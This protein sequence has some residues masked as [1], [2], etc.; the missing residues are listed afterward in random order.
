[1]IQNKKA[2]S[3][4]GLREATSEN[5]DRYQNETT[6]QTKQ[7][8]KVHQFETVIAS[9]QETEA[10][11]L[12]NREYL[13][14]IDFV[15]QEFDLLLRSAPELPKRVDDT[16]NTRMSTD[17]VAAGKT[18]AEDFRS[19]RNQCKVHQPI[20]GHKLESDRSHR[21]NPTS[22]LAPKNEHNLVEVSKE[23]TSPIVTS[24]SQNKV[25]QAHPTQKQTTRP[26]CV[27]KGYKQAPP[28]TNKQT[29]VKTLTTKYQTPQTLRMKTKQAG[30]GFKYSNS[31]TQEQQ[32]VQPLTADSLVPATSYPSW[33]AS[34]TY[35]NVAEDIPHDTVCYQNVTSDVNMQLKDEASYENSRSMP[36]LLQIREDN[37]QQL[38]FRSEAID[39]DEYMD[40]D[41]LY[42]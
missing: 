38:L 20:T 23:Y 6:F 26:P 15:V 34:P 17:A 4:T 21:M 1:M 33:T 27:S 13:T 12:P 16:A 5:D 24:G 31:S 19:D 8:S 39:E 35:L 41:S 42:F 14:D 10:P 3:S 30:P 40:M 11:D 9:L 36:N 29:K 32:L 7:E 25:A 37:Y 28:T 2:G 22:Q 18:T